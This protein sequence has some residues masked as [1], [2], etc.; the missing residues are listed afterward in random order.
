MGII[1]G[2]FRG[3][4]SGNVLLSRAQVSGVGVKPRADCAQYHCG[5][6]S[7]ES[8][9]REGVRFE[10]AVHVSAEKPGIS[11][12]LDLVAVDTKT[13]RLK[14]VKYKRGEPKPDPMDEIQLCAQ[15]L[16]LEEMTGQIVNEGALWYMQTRHR[17][18]VVFSDGLRAQTL[19]TIAAVRALLNSGQT[20]PPDYGKRC[21]ACSLV[22]IC[23][24]ELLGKR[25]RSVG[26]V[27]GLFG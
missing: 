21:K 25:D 20:P 3:R 11:G 4:Q 26:Y 12:V 1:W 10:W 14:P 13:G 22:E 18:P 2:G 23:Q 19:A 24:P 8:E 17:V 6:D 9:M 27:E 5:K 16:C 7:D 15:G